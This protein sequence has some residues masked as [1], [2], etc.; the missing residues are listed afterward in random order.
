M[1]DILSTYSLSVTAKH[2]THIDS[3]DLHDSPMGS[4]CDHT[5]FT[6]EKRGVEMFN[7]SAGKK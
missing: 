3:F 2:L 4:D 1:A 7:N 5:H 6:G